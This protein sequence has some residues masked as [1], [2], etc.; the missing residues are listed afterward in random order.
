MG[1]GGGPD[2]AGRALEQRAGAAEWAREFPGTERELAV[3]RLGFFTYRPVPERARDGRLPGGGLAGLL[4]D[5]WVRAEPIVYED[6]LPRS[7]AGI[8]QSNLS[9]E[10]RKDGSRAAAGYDGAWLSG[11]MGREVLD[12]FALY[13]AQQDRSLREVAG[14][15]GPLV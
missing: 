4:E 11:A 7:A 8:F 14:T 12:P 10:G 6:F 13:E 3:G 9:G 1:G 2:A 5:G 15:F